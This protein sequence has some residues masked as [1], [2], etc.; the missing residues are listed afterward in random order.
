MNP[1]R[2]EE[3][4]P[5]ARPARRRAWPLAVLWIA[6]GALALLAFS[7]LPDTIPVHFDYEGRP[8]AWSGAS[9]AEWMLMWLVSGALGALVA[10]AAAAIH[11]LPERWLSLPRKEEFLALP[12]ER[13][14]RVLDAVAFHTLVIGGTV[15]GVMAAIHAAAALPALGLTE[16]F[17]TE[18]VWVAMAV[19]FL[20]TGV[21]IARLSALVSREVREH[22]RG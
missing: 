8:D 12:P 10:L 20:E 1:A 18:L 14:V 6:H 4:D 3:R 5:G 13:R 2:A 16:R 22:R 19:V 17:P 9:L 21:F 7:R 11:R 15:M